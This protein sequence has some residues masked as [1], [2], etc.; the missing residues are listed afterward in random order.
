MKI[1]LTGATGFIGAEIL[2]QC[3]A[4]PAVTSLIAVAR[5]PLPPNTPDANNPKL[6]VVI[7]EDF[8]VWP[9]PVLEELKGAESCL[10]YA[11]LFQTHLL[12]NT[13]G[14]QKKL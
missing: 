9:A 3:L 4:N 7:Q 8:L 2:Q 6:K 14:S 1:I 11:L 10:W 13:P 5:R 12:L